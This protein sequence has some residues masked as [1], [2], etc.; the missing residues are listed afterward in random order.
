MVKALITT[1]LFFVAATCSAI[2]PAINLPAKVN[3]SLDSK[4][5]N[6][7]L[8]G[9]IKII[10][11][12]SQKVDTTTFTFK[13]KPLQVQYVGEERPQWAPATTAS[14]SL[15][16]SIYTFS[17]E[18]EARGLYVFDKVSV[19]VGKIRVS[20]IPFSYEIVGTKISE[21]LA[22][23]ARL[24]DR[25][26]IYPGQKVTFEYR[27][28]FRY[29]IKLT[30]E[31]LPLL[32][33]EGFRNVGAPEMTDSSSGDYT[34]QVIS[35]R[36]IAETVGEVD[37]GVSLIEGYAY[38]VD[39]SGNARQISGIFHAE[40]PAVKVSVFP[41]PAANRPVS[42]NGAVGVFHI[43][44]RVL[45]TTSITVGE[46]IRLELLVTGSGD[47]ETVQMPDLSLQSL[48]KRSFLF[49]D[50]APLGQVDGGVKRFVVELRPLTDTIRE[51]P[52]IEFS[53]FDPISKTY[54]VKQSAP[55]A[56]TVTAALSKKGVEKE[57]ELQKSYHEAQG[58]APIEIQRNVA[59]GETEI[60]ERDLDTIIL[61]WAV[62]VAIGLLAIQVL[63]RTLLKE[64]KAKEGKSRDLLLEAIK[65]RTS[66][67]A[68]CRQITQALLLS[69]YEMGYTKE[70]MHHPQ[71]L[72]DNGLEGEIKKLLVSIDQKRFTGLEAQ[73]EINEII[74]EA[75]TLYHRLKNRS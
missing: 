9:T 5:E 55:I 61:V 67:D 3:V 62:V 31:Q 33:M 16:V 39:A 40:A 52:S 6:Q 37:S 36:A 56:I 30:R 73:M 41:F 32:D 14:E 38:R 7:P 47:L 48:F 20:S 24:L 17:L 10:R 4:F 28:F 11:L 23:Q 44:A 68:A 26:P 69:L 35:Q 58:L 70:V 59:L 29:P 51:I 66:P 13:G 54:V 1:L 18:P 22:L 45:G 8:T 64:A 27:I 49:S 57:K 19:E 53:S 15:V 63:L 12:A 42:F 75:T 43:Q 74:H 65:S 2:G 21:E 71:Q 25:G 60:E 34:V 72:R 50:L 46:K